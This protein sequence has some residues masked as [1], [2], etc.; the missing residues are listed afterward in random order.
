MNAGLWSDIPT[1]GVFLPL[2]LTSMAKAEKGEQ[3]PLFSPWT[4]SRFV[5]CLRLIAA[6]QKALAINWQMPL[7]EGLL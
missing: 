5:S 1:G 2:P 7:G 6:R 3:Q 4:G